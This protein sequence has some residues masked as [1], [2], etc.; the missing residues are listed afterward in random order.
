M[1]WQ[2]DH[3]KETKFP[4]TGRHA[5][6]PCHNC[7]SQLHVRVPTLPMDCYSCHSGDDAHQGAFGRVCSAC[8]TTES[9]S[10]TVRRR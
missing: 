8:H 7:H 3:G 4:L 10:G 1:L 2:F 6:V 5:S 9:F